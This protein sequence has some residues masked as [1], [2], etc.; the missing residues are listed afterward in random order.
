VIDWSV[1]EVG[2]MRHALG[3]AALGMNTT[4]P[5]PRVGCVLVR[6]GQ[7]VGEGWHERAG[8]PHAE[9]RALQAAGAAAEG[10]T[11]YV[12]LEPCAAQGRTPPCTDALIN[13][14][15]ARVVFAAEDPNPRMRNGAEL[16]RAAGISVHSGLLAGQAR[17]LNPGFFRRHEAGL[18]W[19]RLK[20]GVSLDGRTA[21]ASG[22][23]RWITSQ[24]ARRDAQ[25]FRARSSAVLTGIGTLLADNPALNV[26]IDGALRQPLRVVLDSRLRSPPTS[27]VFEREGPSLVMAAYDDA[28]RRA[29]LNAAGAEVEILPPDAHGHVALRAALERLAQRSVNELWVEAGAALSG[30]LLSAGLV[31]ELIIY[32]AP[33]LLGS[34]AR[35]MAD[36]PALA[37]LDAR[38]RFQLH[39]NQ[40]VG[41]DLRLTL[42]PCSP[43]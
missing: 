20:L 24:A 31:D 16:L 9:V 6:D 27:R 30:A 18:P 12:T 40:Q 26:R 37:S 35:G 43:A 3:L 7:M 14:R 33:C 22:E 34:N 39:E 28:A 5:N 8:A 29:A 4:D 23:S 13:A 42:R 15:V 38:L 1:A 11:A 36:I 2:F 19:V 32:Y 41:E 17:A 25:Q 21:L 10:A